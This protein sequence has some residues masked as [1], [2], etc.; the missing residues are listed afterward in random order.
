M[1][2]GLDAARD[3]AWAA[4]AHCVRDLI[5]P[6]QFDLIAGPWNSVIA[7]GAA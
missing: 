3:A 4:V 7:D 5:T 2:M 6:E 1:A